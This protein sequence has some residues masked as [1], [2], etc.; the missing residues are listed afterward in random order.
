M[1][2]VRATIVPRK[3]FRNLLRCRWRWST[4]KICSG[5]DILFAYLFRIHLTHRH[6]EFPWKIWLGKGTEAEYRFRRLRVPVVLAFWNT[7]IE[8]GWVQ[9]H[10][11]RRCESHHWRRFES[12]AKPQQN[13][14]GALRSVLSFLHYI[15]A[16]VKWVQYSAPTKF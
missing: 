2:M 15:E 11:Q 14:S 4:K 5:S 10:C 1:Q 7:L 9:F 12:Y 16:P 13:F 8:T 3:I 6:Q